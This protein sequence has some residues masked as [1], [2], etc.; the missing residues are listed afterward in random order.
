MQP[1]NL[2]HGSLNCRYLYGPMGLLAHLWTSTGPRAHGPT[3]RGLRA[4]GLIGSGHDMDGTRDDDDDEDEDEDGDEDDADV[5]DDSVETDDEKDHCVD[6]AE[7]EVE[8]DDVDDDEV[9]GEENYDVENDNVEDEDCNDVEDNDV[10]EGDRSHDRDSPGPTFCASLPMRK[11]VTETI[12]SRNLQAN[13]TDI[14][15][16][17]NSRR[18]FCASLCSRNA[19]GHVTRTNL[20][21]KN[22]KMPWPTSAED[23]EVH[24]DDVEDDRG[25]MMMDEDEDENA[26]NEEEVEDVENK[27]EED[28]DDDEDVEDDADVREGWPALLPDFPELASHFSTPRTSSTFS[29]PPPHTLIADIFFFWR[30]KHGKGTSCIFLQHAEWKLHI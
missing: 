28:D 16:K 12:S 9:K 5:E 30:L 26:E 3:V 14:K 23:D 10:E 21:K 8:A 20:C 19:Q 15:R 24:D 17:R 4:Q 25:G 6:V 7:E 11:H 22:K 13:K 27:V 18:T 29:P 1:Q 2:A